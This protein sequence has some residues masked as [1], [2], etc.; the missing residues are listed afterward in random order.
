M[1]NAVQMVV[2]VLDAAAQQILSFQLEPLT[3]AVLC[4]HLDRDGAG[5]SAVVAREGQTA[6]VAVSSS[7]DTARISGLTKSMNLYS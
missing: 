6:L 3:V 2:L 4:A 1:G 7:S 5:H